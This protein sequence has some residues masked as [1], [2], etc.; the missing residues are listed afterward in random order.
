MLKKRDIG[1]MNMWGD[2]NFRKVA[3][4]FNQ[5]GAPLQQSDDEIEESGGDKVLC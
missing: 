4:F 2:E 5:K 1:I 3:H